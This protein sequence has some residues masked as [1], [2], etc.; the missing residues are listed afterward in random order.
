MAAAPPKHRKRWLF[1]ALPQAKNADRVSPV[2]YRLSA[3][4]YQLSAISYR[5][6]TLVLALIKLTYPPIGCIPR[7]FT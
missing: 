6:S 2:H 1:S 7:K 5:L 3:I 4:G